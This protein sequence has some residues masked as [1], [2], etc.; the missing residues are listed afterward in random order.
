MMK[1]IKEPELQEI[2]GG[3][4]LFINNDGC[5]PHNCSCEGV[6]GLCVTVN[7]GVCGCDNDYGC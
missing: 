5:N 7:V 6:D 2:N 3:W 4:C 1:F